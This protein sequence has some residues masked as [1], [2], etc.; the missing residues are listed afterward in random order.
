M[1]GGRPASARG[2]DIHGEFMAA[3]IL[4]YLHEIGHTVASNKTTPSSRPTGHESRY[5][6]SCDIFAP[7]FAMLRRRAAAI[8]ATCWPSVSSNRAF[9][10]KG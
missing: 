3:D 1:E 8:R 9:I 5:L 6:L 4:H 10:D 7:I 2:S